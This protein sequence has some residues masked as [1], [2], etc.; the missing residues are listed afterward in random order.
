MLV[1]VR[2]IPVVTILV[3]NLTGAY[4]ARRDGEAPTWDDLPVQYADYTLWQRELLGT[5]EDPDSV[6]ARQSAFWRD[7]L[8]GVPEELGLPFDRP[9]PLVASHRG[10]DVPGRSAGSAFQ[11]GSDRSTEASVSAVSS[12]PN[13]RR[14]V[15]IS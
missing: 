9:R 12:P 15:S 1:F 14:A 2:Y 10:A 6:V 5:E 4:A 7:A 8:A 3:H 13:A 11:S